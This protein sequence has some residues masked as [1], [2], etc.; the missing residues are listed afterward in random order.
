MGRSRFLQCDEYTA[1]D[2]LSANALVSSRRK[3]NAPFKS[4][5]R[6]FQPVDRGSSKHIWEL[7]G[8]GDEKIA[9]VNDRFNLIGVDA[10]QSHKHENLVIGLK[11]VDRW[12]P[13]RPQFGRLRRP[14]NLP[15]KPLRAEEHCASLRPHQIRI[16][17]VHSSLSSRSYAF[18]RRRIAPAG[19][20]AAPV[21]ASLTHDIKGKSQCHSST[22]FDHTKSISLAALQEE[23][24]LP[25]DECRHYDIL[26]RKLI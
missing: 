12:F 3:P 20:Q 2:H 15:V 24:D 1:I 8:P 9:A 16:I 18:R 10:W 13:S 7:A 17:S 23:Q 14:K 22:A 26:P 21:N 11:N 6:Q 4:P 25:R 19:I 5:L